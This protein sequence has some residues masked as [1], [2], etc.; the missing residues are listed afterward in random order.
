MRLEIWCGQW[1]KDKRSLQPPSFFRYTFAGR[2][3][4]GKRAFIDEIERL[5]GETSLTGQNC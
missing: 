3:S 1:R 5:Y 4:D 2:S